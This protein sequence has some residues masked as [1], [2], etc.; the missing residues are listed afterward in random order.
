M[1]L[2]GILTLLT[3][4]I[5]FFVIMSLIFRSN[6][7]ALGLRLFDQVMLAVTGAPVERLS[8]IT[9]QLYVG[10]Q[11]NERGWGKLQAMG[12]TAVVNMR[13]EFDDATVGIAPERY[14]HLPTIDHTAPSMEQLCEGIA[15]IKDEIENGGKVYIHCASGIGRAPTMACAYF[16]STGLTM[17]EA[18]A[19][20]K[21]KRPFIRPRRPQVEQ[22]KR[23]EV[24]Q[25]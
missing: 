20:I 13:E 23:F 24:E 2:T 19:T 4:I 18:R 16:I 1:D 9:P 11:H 21:R 15:F 22:L 10:G 3:Q 8:R 25:C 6:P 7:V 12:I 17:K 14:L 5:L